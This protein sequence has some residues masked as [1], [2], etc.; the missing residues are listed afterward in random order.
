MRP[1]WGAFCPLLLL[2]WHFQGTRLHTLSKQTH[3]FENKNESEGCATQRKL[4]SNN[5]C[6]PLSGIELC[7]FTIE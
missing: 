3:F 6:H 4:R 2:L 5:L 7:V 1:P